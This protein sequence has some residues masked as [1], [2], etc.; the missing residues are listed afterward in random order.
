VA[1][2]ALGLLAVLPGGVAQPTPVGA[3]DCASGSTGTLRVDVIDNNTDERV[4][5]TGIV[6][7]FS[8]DTQDAEGTDNVTDADN[9]TG[10]DNSAT[11]GRIQQNTTCSTEGSETYSVTI[12]SL[13]AILD[14]NCSIVD[15]NDSGTV[16]DGGTTTLT[17]HID[18]DTLPTATPTTPTVTPTTTATVTPTVSAI[19][20]VTVSAAPTSVNCSGSS[21]VTVV[22]KAGGQNVPDGT[23]VS[24]STNI[25]SLSP[26]TA[27]T[28]G[29]GILTIFTAGTTGGV[30]TITA[31]SGGVSGTAS[32]T[33]NCGAPTAVPPTAA[34]PPPPP[35]PPP[36]SGGSIP[37]N[38]GDAGLQSSSNSWYAAGAVLVIA[39]AALAGLVVVRRRS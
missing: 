16:A 33:V 13:P 7:Q 18:C 2:I 17:V 14:D 15:G 36:P 23:N 37:P 6:V 31:T 39:G 34:P 21:F 20:G 24:V 19:S 38:T 35:P 28:S 32:V 8:P 27:P 5:V 22:V 10:E 30:A 4:T 29:G 1:L 12:Q 11:V 26:T 9:N 3:Y 25:G